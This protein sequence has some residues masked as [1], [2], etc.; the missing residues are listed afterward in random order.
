MTLGE[1]TV[2]SAIEIARSVDGVYAFVAATSRGDRNTSAS[3][4]DGVIQSRVRR[5]W[6]C[7]QVRVHYLSTITLETRRDG[8]G[9]AGTTWE[10]TPW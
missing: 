7:R 3:F 5:V 9:Q 1:Y 2:G 10:Q 8:L 4:S 6:R